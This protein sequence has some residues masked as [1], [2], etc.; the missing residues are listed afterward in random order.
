MSFAIRQ[1]VPIRRGFLQVVQTAVKRLD[2]S[3]LAAHLFAQCFIL[4]LELAHLFTE[5]VNVVV[6]KKVSAK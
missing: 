6:A 4:A 3:L 5:F 1:N 2:E